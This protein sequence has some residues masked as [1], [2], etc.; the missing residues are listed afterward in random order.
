MN[1]EK[2]GNY[3]YITLFIFNLMYRSS[4]HVADDGK[5]GRAEVGW[6]PTRFINV[7]GVMGKE[8]GECSAIM[9]DTKYVTKK[10]KKKIG[11]YLW[12]TFK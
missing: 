6:N 12:K 3:G 8:H 5:A 2:G 1:A 7:P 11:F 9:W 4:I 10:K